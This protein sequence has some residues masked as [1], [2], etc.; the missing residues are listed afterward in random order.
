MTPI[1][2]DLINKVYTETNRPDLE[3][4]T[5]Q[6]VL[7]S[8]QKMHGLDYFFRD[9]KSAQVQFDS[10]A[11]LQTL[12][13]DALTRFKAIAYF[14]KWD[15]NYSSY[16]QNPNLLPPLYYT[17]YGTVL[18][19]NEALRM[20]EAVAPDDIFDSY[21]CEKFDVYYALGSTLMIKS[22][23]SFL[24]ARIGW[25]AFPDIGLDTY[26]SWIARQFPYSIIYDSA[27][28][29]LQKIG[30]QDVARKYD[31]TDPNNPGLVASHMFE[32]KMS[33]V[34]IKGY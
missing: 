12:D 6:A 33:N 31:N 7:S 15:P 27:S 22:R 29:I 13:M 23:T 28:A 30:M 10:A 34:I 11:Y 17:N 32:L 5:L 18:G 26:D 3:A 21:G 20:L 9:I 14:R 25:Y 4:E 19:E 24:Y 2:T 1:L 16:Q 8:T